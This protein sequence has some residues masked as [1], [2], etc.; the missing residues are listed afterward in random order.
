MGR[1]PA[2][3]Q[4]SDF[5]F[6]KNTDELFSVTG[7]DQ[8]MAPEVYKGK[9]VEAY[10]SSVDI[11]SLGVTALDCFMGL[12]H[13]E[14]DNEWGPR[15]ID[16]AWG[17]TGSSGKLPLFHI[18]RLC[19]F[20]ILAFVFDNTF[21]S[22][23][24]SPSCLTTFIFPVFM[25]HGEVVPEIRHVLTSVCRSFNDLFRLGIHAINDSQRQ[26]QCN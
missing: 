11:W 20:F 12:P 3:Y 4:L 21:S 8:Y 2:V 9:G 22:Y 1:G 18:L 6:V 17:K 5:G 25:L 13:S 10:D 19:F 7:T 26:M 16:W 14:V 24:S 15:L 23:F